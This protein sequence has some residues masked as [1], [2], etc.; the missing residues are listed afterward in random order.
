MTPCARL[1]EAFVDDEA[2]HDVAEKVRRR[3][4]H[5]IDRKIAALFEPLLNM[6]RDENPCRGWRAVWP[7]KLVEAMGVIPRAQIANDIKGAWT[8]DCARHVAQAWCAFSGSSPFS[9]R[10]C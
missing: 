9:C 1:V 10:C 5:F 8:K 4:Q 7:S 3:L 2:G 6:S